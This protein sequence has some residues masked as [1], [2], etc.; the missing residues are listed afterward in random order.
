MTKEDRWAKKLSE[1]NLFKPKPET[2]DNYKLTLAELIRR[3][4]FMIS[5]GGKLYQIKV[6]EVE[7][8]H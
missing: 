7:F 1:L 8:T 5:C 3:K 4:D 6:K 2:P